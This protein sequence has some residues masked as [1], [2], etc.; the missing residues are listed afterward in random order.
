MDAIALFQAQV[1]PVNEFGWGFRPSE[2]K[3]EKLKSY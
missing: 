2:K 3:K 1:F